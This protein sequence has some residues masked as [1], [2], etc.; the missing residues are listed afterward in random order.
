[1]RSL[2]D[3][4]ESFEKNNTVAVGIS[5]DSVPSKNA[6]A[7]TLGI[8]NTRLLSDFWLHGNVAR[9]LGIFRENDGISE[10]ANIIVDEDQNVKFIKIYE[11]ST[12]PDI[13]EIIGEIEK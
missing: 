3:N 13:K 11:I 6:W 2:E 9:L 10:R 5:V 7:V 4:L 8:R 12:L 1:M